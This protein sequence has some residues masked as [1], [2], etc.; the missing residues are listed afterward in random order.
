M[1]L[2]F[3]VTKMTSVKSLLL[4]FS[5]LIDMA[6]MFWF[7]RSDLISSISISKGRYFMIIFSGLLPLGLKVWN[8]IFCF[9]K[10]SIK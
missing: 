5:L 10:L 3:V 1:S 2:V 9:L 4:F 7:K 6:E 8:S